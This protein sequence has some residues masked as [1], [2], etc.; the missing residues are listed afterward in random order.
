M[1]QQY[2]LFKNERN[3]FISLE[4]EDGKKKYKAYFINKNGT[5]KSIT[6][7]SPQYINDF[8]EALRLTEASEAEHAIAALYRSDPSFEIIED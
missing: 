4:L 7:I 8:K 1:L 6:T 5:Y 2:K 3:R